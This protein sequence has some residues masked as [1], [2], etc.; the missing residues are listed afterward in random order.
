VVGSQIT[1]EA[2]RTWFDAARSHAYANPGPTAATFALVV[3][4]PAG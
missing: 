2:R 1:P 4:E 3:L